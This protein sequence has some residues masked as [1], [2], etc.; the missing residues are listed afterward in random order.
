MEEVPAILKKCVSKETQN[1][2]FENCT[3]EQGRVNVTSF[4]S[5]RNWREAGKPAT[6]LISFTRSAKC[7]FSKRLVS[8]LLSLSEF[9]SNWLKIIHLKSS[10]NPK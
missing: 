4:C 8:T 2:T 1:S 7:S 3:R 10:D 5:T 6:D 9:H